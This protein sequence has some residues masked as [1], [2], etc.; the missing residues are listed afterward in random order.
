LWKKEA[1]EEEKAKSQHDRINDVQF[2][3]KMVYKTWDCTGCRHSYFYNIHRC[4]L[5]ESGKIVENMHP[6]NGLDS[7]KEI[8]EYTTGIK[9][10]VVWMRILHEKRGDEV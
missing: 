2:H 4:L 8:I 10:E 7:K 6:T 9:G 3:R 1:P 5:C